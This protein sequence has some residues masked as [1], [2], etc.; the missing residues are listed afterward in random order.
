[1][2]ALQ[3]FGLGIVG[4]IAATAAHHVLRLALGSSPLP[5]A[6]SIFLLTLGIVGFTAYR[7]RSPLWLQFG[8][9]GLGLSGLLAWH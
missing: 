3:F 5:Y 4:T 9:I 6:L 1:M 2:Q 7:N 8:L